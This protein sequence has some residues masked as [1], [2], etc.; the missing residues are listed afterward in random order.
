MRPLSQM[1]TRTS[2]FTL[3]TLTIAGFTAL[4]GQSFAATIT[5]APEKETTPVKVETIAKGL[6]NPWGLQFLP[7]GRMLVTERSGD[8]HIVDNAG[9]VSKPVA[10]VPEVRVSRQGGLLDV[11]LAPDF[12]ASGRLFLSY[13]E[14]QGGSKSGTSVASARLALASDDSGTLED[15]KVIFRQS[16]AIN[17]GL[18]FG[19]RVV[20]AK[21]GSLFITT[22]DRGTMR[23]AAQ[24]P[25]IPIG[26]VIRITPDGKPHP[27]NPK[28]DGWAP[29]IWSIGHRNIQG[30]AIDPDTGALWTVEHGARGGDELNQPKPGLNYGWPV[31]T[32]GRDYSGAKIGIGQKKEGMEQPVYYWDPSIAV[33]GLTIYD[34]DMFPEWK[35]S[36]LIG[37]LAGA[38]IARLELA[39]GKVVSE[40]KLLA[41]EG[42]RIRDVRQ[43]P[44]GAIY[45]LVDQRDGVILRLTPE[46]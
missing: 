40:E 18:H 15:V 14:P 27:D 28:K 4:A 25:K 42:Y 34:G 38:Q 10:G 23:D 19:S 9:N 46:K 17:S 2:F 7:D 5:Q 22:G 20:I 37:G 8:L 32:Y 3:S 43:G 16:P 13:S 29:E 44:E 39:D 35:G 41:A 11:R 30:A 33:S 31:I 45:A 6:A 1:S 12:E 21:D 26:A 36:F 24:D